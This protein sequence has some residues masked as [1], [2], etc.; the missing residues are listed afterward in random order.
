MGGV[1]P[2]VALRVGPTRGP[3]IP[4]LDVCGTS[5]VYAWRLAVHAH[6][7]RTKADQEV[8]EALALLGP[9]VRCF[10][11]RARKELC[12]NTLRQDPGSAVRQWDSAFRDLCTVTRRHDFDVEALQRMVAEL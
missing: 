2:G 8:T 5:S 1:K 6:N 4:A 11:E 7:C 9:G 10:G 12:L 3:R